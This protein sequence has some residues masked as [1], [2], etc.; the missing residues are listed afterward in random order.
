MT[1]V[2]ETDEHTEKFYAWNEKKTEEK[3]PKISSLTDKGQR[4]KLQKTS[5]D[6]FDLSLKEL[7]E[8]FLLRYI[9]K[10]LI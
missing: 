10:G 4:K 3:Y 7:I 6:V 8:H 1:S 9:V 2:S 5:L